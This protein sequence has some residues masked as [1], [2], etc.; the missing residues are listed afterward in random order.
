MVANQE[1]TMVAVMEE[2]ALE[3]VMVVETTVAGA[4]LAGQ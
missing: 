3:V 2:A 4:E 1:A